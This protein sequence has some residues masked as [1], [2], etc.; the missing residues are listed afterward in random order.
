MVKCSKLGE[1]YGAIWRQVENEG[2]S[3]FSDETFRINNCE[4][5]MQRKFNQNQKIVKCSKL[6]KKYRA[7]WQ[8]RRK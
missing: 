3:L 8:L 6:G 5:N 7:F 4:R 2:R 1:I